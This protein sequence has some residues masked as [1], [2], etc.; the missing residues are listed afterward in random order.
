M[1]LGM[2]VWFV[3]VNF[4]MWLDSWG[5]IIVLLTGPLSYKYRFDGKHLI[6]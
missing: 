3:K 6:C 5:Q 1:Y 2:V 4:T